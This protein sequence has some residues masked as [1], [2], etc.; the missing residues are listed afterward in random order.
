MMDTM[1][2]IN[3]SESEE[4]IGE[5]TK[6]RPIA[7]IPISGRYRVIDFILSNMVNA[8][9]NNIAIFTH[10]KSRSLREHLGS[11]KEWDLDRK[12]DGLFVFNSEFSTNQRV[13]HKGDLDNFKNNLD[14][15]KTSRQEYVVLSRS[16]MICNINLKEAIRYHKES[17]VDMTI[18]YK[19]VDN[20]DDK[21]LSCDVLSIDEDGK[22]KGIGVNLGRKEKTNLSMEIYIMKKDLLLKIIEDSISSGNYNYLKNAIYHNISNLNVNAFKFSGYLSCINTTEN[23]YK[24]NMEMLNYDQYKE[25]FYRHGNIYTKIK[26]GAPAKYK[27]DAVIKNSIIANG[28]IIEGTVENSIIGRGVKIGKGAVIKD[29][30]IM[31]KCNIDEG[32]YIENA[33]LDKNV[34]ITKNKLLRGDM[35]KPLVIG[36]DYEL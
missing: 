21:F 17:N 24:T 7:S 23:Y 34:I 2:I 3:L 14:Y 13:L 22:V 18:V 19:E 16:Y 31:A 27:D 35:K 1:G 6:N 10:G 33:I 36:K 25:L 5:L 8:G 20:S 4:L 12:I 32:V 9:I 15:I 26:D 28:C 30:V 29:S 11:G